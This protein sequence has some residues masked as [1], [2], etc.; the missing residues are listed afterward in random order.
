MDVNVHVAVTTAAPGITTS[1]LCLTFGTMKY[2]QETAIKSTTL[3]T[4]NLRNSQCLPTTS[5]II[6]TNTANNTLSIITATIIKN[7][8]IL[9]IRPSMY[10]GGADT[11][12][13][14]FNTCLI[15]SITEDA[16]HITPPIATV[17]RLW[18]GPDRISSILGNSASMVSCGNSPDNTSKSLVYRN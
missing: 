13:A 6:G 3:L 15:P 10:G 4:T 5:K 9:N 12:R 8:S 1:I 18:G 11:L 16:V 2:I 7:C 17:R 14:L